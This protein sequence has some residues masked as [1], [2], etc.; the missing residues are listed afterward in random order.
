MPG[1][2]IR[3]AG[4]VAGGK[5][6]VAQEMISAG[7][8]DL[9]A[10]T[11]SVWAAIGAKVR[12]PDG[13]YPVRDDDDLLLPL[14]LYLKITVAR[15]GLERDLRV[16]KT[17]STPTDLPRDRALASEF[18]ASFREIVVDPG[19]DVVRDR[20]RGEDGDVSEACE[21]ALGHWYRSGGRV[22]STTPRRR[23]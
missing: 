12:G 16:V 9:I 22:I 5:S 11:S 14:A 8:A 23:R 10:D 13:R 18:G 17:S 6:Q 21:Q 15:Q 20:L 4:P 19:E 7:E 2:L 1:S 3:I